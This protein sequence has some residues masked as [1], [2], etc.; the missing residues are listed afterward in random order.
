MASFY[1]NNEFINFLQFGLQNTATE[2]KHLM[3]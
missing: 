3:S 2:F 1:K